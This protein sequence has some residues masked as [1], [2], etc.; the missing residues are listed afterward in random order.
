MSTD[1]EEADP[2]HELHGHVDQTLRVAMA[3]AVQLAYVRAERSLRDRTDT[4]ATDPAEP[5][6]G[7]APPGGRPGRGRGDVAPGQ[8][9][10]VVGPGHAR[11]GGPRLRSG[12]GR[13]RRS[14]PTRPTPWSASTRNSAPATDWTSTRTSGIAHSTPSAKALERRPWTRRCRRPEAAAGRR[15]ANGPLAATRVGPDVAGPMLTS[16]AWP[17]LETRLNELD[18]MGVDSAQGARRRARRPGHGRGQGRGPGAQVPALAR[19]AEGQGQGTGV[20]REGLDRARLVNDTIRSSEALPTRAPARTPRRPRTPRRHS[21][22]QVGPEHERGPGGR[23]GP[24]R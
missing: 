12:T 22:R 7:A 2:V 18:A 20:E 17:A 4:E 16:A 24:E 8:R 6:Q 9:T 15:R 19:R 23:D 14:I 11:P 10:G 13:T 5:G 21:G 1:F 3:G